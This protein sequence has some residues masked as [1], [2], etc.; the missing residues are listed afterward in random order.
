MSLQ[1]TQES[2][3][4]YLKG[5]LNS[6]TTESFI[7]RFEYNIGN[8]NNIIIN[9]DNLNE[10]DKFGIEAIKNLRNF[11]LKYNKK[12]S[13]IGRGARDIYDHFNYFNVA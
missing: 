10:I 1:I 7:D 11:A 2:N 9:I 8:Q 6:Q 3:K 4:F 13:I 5:E 12:F